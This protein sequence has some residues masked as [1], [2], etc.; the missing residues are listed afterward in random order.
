VP[1]LNVCPGT[2]SD[3]VTGVLLFLKEN[4]LPVLDITCRCNTSR[5]GSLIKTGKILGTLF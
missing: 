2:A 4:S 5:L 1:V 3:I